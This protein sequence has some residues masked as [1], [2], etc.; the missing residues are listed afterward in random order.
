[1]LRTVRTERGCRLVT[2]GRH[3]PNWLLSGDRHIHLDLAQPDRFLGS[4]GPFAQDAD[5]ITAAVFGAGIDCRL[6]AWNVEWLPML[7]TLEVNCLTH[8]I[9]LRALLTLRSTDNPLRIVLLSSDVVGVPTAGSIVY[10]MSK[11][12]LEEGLSQAT[13]DVDSGTLRI[14]IVRLGFAG[15]EMRE[16]A[17]ALPTPLVSP[18]PPG[19]GAD[20]ALEAVKTFL[21]DP[22]PLSLP[23]VTIWKA[24]TGMEVPDDVL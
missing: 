22:R 8:L 24:R 3:R 14:L 23:A 7:R 19:K 16:V 10:G 6:H 18:K 15:T 20:T 4:L 13:A 1:M 2:L 11:A 5:R 21:A 9:L 12:A 17:E